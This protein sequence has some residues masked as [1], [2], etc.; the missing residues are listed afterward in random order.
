MQEHHLKCDTDQFQLYLSGKKKTDVRID[1]GRNFQEGDILYQHEQ[2][3]VEP[4]GRIISMLVT[5]VMRELGPHWGL[6]QMPPKMVIMS[7]HGA[8]LIEPGKKDRCTC[9]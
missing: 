9:P 5:H 1:D 8:F 4:T 3:G 6:G 2:E 7:I